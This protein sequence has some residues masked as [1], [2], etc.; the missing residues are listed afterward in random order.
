MNNYGIRY[1]AL[2]MDARREA[3][4]MVIPFASFATP[5]AREYAATLRTGAAL[6]AYRCCKPFV[7]ND[8]TAR[9]APWSAPKAAPAYVTVIH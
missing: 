6:G 9:L 3:Q 4:R 7:V 5:Q 2:A 8:T 1:Y